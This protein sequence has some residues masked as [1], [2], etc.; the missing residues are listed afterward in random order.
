MLTIKDIIIGLI[1]LIIILALF[2]LGRKLRT[3]LEESE[4]YDED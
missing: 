2:A 4:W 1:A 3:G